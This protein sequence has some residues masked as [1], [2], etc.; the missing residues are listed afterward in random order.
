MKQIPTFRYER[1]LWNQGCTVI[2]VDEVGRGALSGPVYVG[3]VC[4]SPC[5]STEEAALQRLGIQDSKQLSQAERER[6]AQHIPHVVQGYTVVARSTSVVNRNG[7]VHAVQ[8][9]MREAIVRLIT[10]LPDTVKP[11]VLVDAFPIPY[12]RGISSKNQLPIVHGDSVSLSVAAASIM[13]KVARDQKMLELS[14]RYPQYGWQEN[15]GYGT[16]DHRSAIRTFGPTPLHRDLFIR[17]I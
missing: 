4:F 6:L 14:E 2:G 16:A 3:A 11:Y 7:I 1:L 15:K 10:T 12:L 5:D 9:A 17:K 8:S 13:A